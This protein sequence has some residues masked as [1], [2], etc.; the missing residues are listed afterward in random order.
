MKRII[1]LALPTIALLC[2]A[3][4]LPAGDALAQ[5]K[6]KVSY[7]VSAENSK[8]TQQHL[9]DVGDVP[10]HEVRIFEI[11]RTFPNNPPMINGVKLV[12]QWT[13]GLTDQTDSKRAVGRPTQAAGA[14]FPSCT[15]Q[16]RTHALSQQS[17]SVL[18]NIRR[19][20]MNRRRMPTLITMALLCFGVALP[21]GT[22]VGQTAR[23]LVG[24]W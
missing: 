23:D 1:T 2:L 13:R 5:Q 22:A 7:K 17:A 10:G 6:Q 9:I 16:R 4:A 14:F 8:Y 3:V 15:F 20:T 11:R 18:R 24:T 12:E 19:N 21:P